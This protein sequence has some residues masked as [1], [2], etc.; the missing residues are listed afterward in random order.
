[1]SATD[2][3]LASMTTP[4]T[5]QTGGRKEQGRAFDRDDVGGA[6]LLVIHTRVGSLLM[7]E[8]RRRV[9]TRMFGIRAEGQ[10]FLV[11]IIVLGAA[12]TVLRGVVARPPRP[13][14]TDLAIGGAVVNTALR[15][16]AGPPS[17]NIPLAGALIGSAVLAHSLRPAAAGSV[18]EIRRVAG[19]V[20]AVFRAVFGVRRA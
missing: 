15:G 11:T 12:T 19:G 8:A 10:S 9:V 4:G 16:I 18:R 14:G 1:M 5:V 20:G 3:P 13:S 17:A 6:R 2:V 7:R